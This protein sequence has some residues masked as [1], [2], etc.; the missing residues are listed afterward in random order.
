MSIFRWSI[1]VAFASTLAAPAAAATTS[2]F[3]A[4]A[5]GWVV[6]DLNCD[7]Y[8]SVLGTFAL[9]WSGS[10]GDPAGNVGLLDR[11][12]NCYFFDAPAAFLGDRSADAGRQVEFSLRTTANDWP[13]G[14]V[15]VLIGNNGVILVHDFAQPSIAWKRYSVTLLAANFRLNTASGAIATPAQ[16]AAVLA[17]LEAFRISAE[18]GSQVAEETSF[19][20]SVAFGVL[21]CAA[22]LNEDGVVDGAD[23]TLVLGAWGGPGTADLDESGTVDGGD[24]TVILGAWG[25]CPS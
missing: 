7:N 1:V 24:I 21:P 17:D 13:P 10:N 18:Y 5:E 14:S 16:F 19:L 15:F 22:D 23:L 25:P 3:D 11:T 12:G 20:D 2:N 6:K 8:G 4:S 9:N